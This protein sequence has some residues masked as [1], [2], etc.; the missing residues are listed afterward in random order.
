[1]SHKSCLQGCRDKS[2]TQEHPAISQK[3]IEE[4]P[5]RESLKSVSQEC[6]KE[7]LDK[8]FSEEFLDN[9]G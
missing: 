1:M 4:C 8:L 7:H 6:H 5:M 3:F 2:F 9:N